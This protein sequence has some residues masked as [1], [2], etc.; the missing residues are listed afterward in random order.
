MKTFLLLWLSVLKPKKK[1]IITIPVS[2]RGRP[3]TAGGP[4]PG[5]GAAE[6][7]RSPCGSHEALAL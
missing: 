3:H 4:S 7:R 5:P 2:G 6:R 1:N